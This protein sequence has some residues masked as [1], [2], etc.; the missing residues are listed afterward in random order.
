MRFGQRRVNVVSEFEPNDLPRQNFRTRTE[1]DKFNLTF[2]VVQN[3]RECVVHEIQLRLIEPEGY[4]KCQF[5]GRSGFDQSSVEFAVVIQ[6]G[7]IAVDGLLEVADHR[8]TA[9]TRRRL[10]QFEPLTMR[11]DRPRDFEQNKKL[12]RIGILSFVDNNAI[13]FGT[14]PL[15]HFRQTQ[16]AGRERDLVRISDRA[17]SETEL[18]IITLHFRGHARRARACPFPQRPKR[19]APA[20]GEIFR[21]RGAQRPWRELIRFAPA[22]QPFAQLR[23]GLGNV[24]RL[25]ALNSGFNFAEIAFRTA[26]E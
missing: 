23:L 24:R 15:R 26:V 1:L 8:E 20:R 10:S 14:N 16:Q 25:R 11:F 13:V 7:R 6:I 4:G 22:P 19:F 12:L 17:T 21:R 18:A 2:S 5:F 9:R 3:F